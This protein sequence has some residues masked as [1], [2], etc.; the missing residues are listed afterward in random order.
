M[1]CY[2][3]GNRL[4][5][6]SIFCNRCGV[7]LRT[8]TE[9]VRNSRPFDTPSPPDSSRRPSSGRF[10]AAHPG[11]DASDEEPDED[12]QD[13][14]ELEDWD[15]DQESTDRDSWAMDDELEEE[16]EEETDLK[17]TA[18][19]PPYR[20][21]KERVIFSINPAFYPVTTSYVVS[22]FASLLIAA[23]VSFLNLGFLVAVGGVVL[24]FL[25]S[26]VRHIRHVHTIFT[27]TSVKLEISEGL[28]SKTTRNI[29]LR[30]IQDVSVRES[31]RERLLGIGDIVLDTPSMET[32]LMLHNVNTPRH[33]AD[34]I[35]EQLE[36]WI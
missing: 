21:P 4:P 6:E 2:R 7:R 5:A 32:R 34:L 26:V 19:A 15:D 36:R 30:H 29:P 10:E 14:I 13:Q 11:R 35:I 12:Y 33:Y 16:E 18:E 9:R 22:T 24:A 31:F 8:T 3:C 17:H 28:F 25:P 27:L 20:G 23:V 1:F